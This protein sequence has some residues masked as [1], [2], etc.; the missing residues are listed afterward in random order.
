MADNKKR[1]KPADGKGSGFKKRKF[2]KPKAPAPRLTPKELKRKRQEARPHFDAVTRAKELWNKLRE[3]ELGKEERRALMDKLFPLIRGKMADI[4]MKHDASRV[5]QCAVKHAT[6]E[7]RTEILKE[8]K[9]HLV[10]LS[11]AQFSHHVVKKLLRYCTR[12]QQQVVVKVFQNKV[13]KLGTHTVGSQVMECAFIWLPRDLWQRLRREF[14]GQEFAFF[15]PEQQ[16]SLRTLLEDT[17]A[18]SAGAGA[19]AGSGAPSGAARRAMQN[20]GSA[21]QRM[22]GKK[23]LDLSFAHDLLAE[24]MDAA[25]AR[26]VLEMASA[27]QDAALQLCATRRGAEVACRCIAV[28]APKLRKHMVK[29]MKEFVPKLCVHPHAYL[30]V[31]RALDVVDDTVLL[32]KQL[33]AEITADS[34]VLFDVATSPTGRKV[35]LHVLRPRCPAYNDPTELRLLEPALLP[36]SLVGGSGGGGG[37][38]SDEVGE[39]E[40]EGES[41]GERMVPTSK[42]DAH[43]RRAELL[44]ALRPAL[45]ELVEGRAAELLC[46][47]SGAD[48]L[49]ETVALF[50]SEEVVG[51]ALAAAM[52]D[53]VEAGEDE[54]EEARAQSKATNGPA[55]G[56]GSDSG[57]SDAGAEDG[58]EVRGGGG[59]GGG[60]GGDDGGVPVK[61]YEHAVGHR[62]LKR[63]AAAPPS[64]AALDGTELVTVGVSFGAR[65]GQRL[66][67]A[68]GLAVTWATGGSRGAHVVLQVLRSAVDASALGAQLL[69]KRA[70][71]TKLRKRDPNHAVGL[72]LDFLDGKLVDK[73]APQKPA[74]KARAGTAA[75][76][77][78]EAEEPEERTS[79]SA[80]TSKP[81]KAGRAAKKR[82]KA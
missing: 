64:D 34:D 44:V 31:M 80:R 2:G 35:L 55:F 71:L 30:F 24:F 1:S 11:K 60:E 26:D 49:V 82:G 52:G 32:R 10:E 9:P 8:L 5:I 39:G 78:Q 12:T 6:E 40:G 47:P 76:A 70:R 72:L 81:K 15:G 7:E 79:A 51:A 14:F 63:L 13:A 53:V 38:G 3:K 48:V 43:R 45:E 77:R 58:E 19:G 17:D 73:K 23:L 74:A 42:K 33:L 56:G 28:G 68:E 27:L 20:V 21:L 36:A 25:P 69:A 41:E 57:D 54:G 66:A 46:H 16:V 65:L 59:G 75:E 22:V 29:T 4:A 50:G 62:T 67:G 18:G 61:P 37:G